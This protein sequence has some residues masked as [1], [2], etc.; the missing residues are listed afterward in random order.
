MD[1]KEIIEYFEHVRYQVACY[2]RD[3]ITPLPVF[4]GS[5]FMLDMG[6]HVIFVTAGH[7]ATTYDGS[8]F[9]D[10]KL[11]TIQTNTIYKDVTTN[12]FGSILITANGVVSVSAFKVDVETGKVS[13]LGVVDVSFA[14]L[15]GERKEAPFVTQKIEFDGAK[16]EYG[17]KKG[18]IPQSDIIPVSSQDVYSVFGRVHF[19]GSVDDGQFLLKSDIIFHENL[20]YVG[21]AGD[22]LVLKYDNPVIVKDWKGLSGSPVLNQ[23]GKLIGVA[24]AVDPIANTLHVMPMHKIL[25]LIK[26]EILQNQ[27]N[28]PCNAIE[29]K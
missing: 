17:E 18:Y 16:V 24:C 9:Y 23:D 13:P 1:R 8:N 21:D 19:I 7:V 11:M 4:S 29:D 3:K 15:L 6:G 2:H 20:K 28:I 26:A 10:D 22:M 25:P 27:Q 5:G 12:K 14:E